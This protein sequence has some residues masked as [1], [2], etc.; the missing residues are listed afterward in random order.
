MR[1]K[2]STALLLGLFGF[3]GGW[4]FMQM[5]EPANLLDAVRLIS[6]CQ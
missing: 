2:L 1:L 3:V 5:L 4:A 6:F